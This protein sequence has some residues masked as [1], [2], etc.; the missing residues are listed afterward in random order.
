MKIIIGGMIGAII[1]FA[2]GYFGKCVSGACPLTSNP[3]V[4]TIIGALIGTMIAL[5]K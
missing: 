4:S 1:G 5:S 2:I 3:I